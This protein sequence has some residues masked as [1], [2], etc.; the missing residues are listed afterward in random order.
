MTLNDTAYKRRSCH[1]GYK[2]LC[3]LCRNLPPPVMGIRY[4]VF[5][6][7]RPCGPDGWLALL[8]TKSGDVETS[9]SPTTTHKHFYICDICLKQ[10]HGRKHISIRCNRH[11]SHTPPVLTGLVK[12]KPNPLIH[13]SLTPCPPTPPRAKYIHISHNPPTP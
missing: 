10:M 12:P 8:F 13:S 11:T 5:L 3:K 7:S 9:Q 1:S 4:T 6:E 2:P